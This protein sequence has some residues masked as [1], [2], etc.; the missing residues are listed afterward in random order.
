M[1]GFSQTNLKYMKTFA[2]AWPDWS[3]GQQLVDQIPWSHNMVV[4]QQI[5]GIEARRWYIKKTIE[6]GWSRNVL[7]LLIESQLYVLQGCACSFFDQALPP[8]QSD[9][10]LQLV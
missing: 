5:K 2:E 4:L 6:N 1:S 7:I 8:S 10:A 9:L 3:I